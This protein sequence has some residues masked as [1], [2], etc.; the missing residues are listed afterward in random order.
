MLLRPLSLALCCL[1]IGCQTNPEGPKAPPLFTAL[2]AAHTGID[3][4]NTLHYNSA[5][6]IYTYRNFYNGG[7]V[8]I[9]D[10]NNDG[11]PDIYLTANME[12]NRLY[13]NQGDFRFEDVSEAAGIQGKGGWCTG[14]AMADVN[15]DG[16][17]DIYVCNSGDLEGDNKQNE[18]F[19]NNGDGT[20][21]EMAEAYGL[22]DR[23]Y[24]THA[25]FFDYDGD[26]DLDCYLLNN[27]YQ[28]ISSFN[29]EK[30]ERPIRD[31]VGGD[32]LFRNNGNGTFTDVSVQAGIYGSVIGF[33]LGVTVGDVNRDGWPDIYVSNDFFER[34]YLYINQ[35]NGTFTEVLTQAMPSISSA[36]MGADMADI[37]H[38]GYPDVFVTEMLP[39]DDDRIKTATTFENWDK[40]RLNVRNGYHHQF[41]RNMLQLNNRDG[42]FS[43]IGRLGGVH[44]S[45]WSW[46]ALLFDMDNDGQ[47][48]I[49]VANGIYQDLTNQ[50][51]IQFISNDE[52]KRA[53]ISREG[54]DYKKLIDY[55]PSNPVPNHAFHNQGNYHFANRAQEWGLA[56]PSFSNGSAYADLDGDGDL[57]LV[58]NNVNM[59]LFIYRN[60]ARQQ[61][62][63]HHYLQLELMGEGANTFAIG[64]S[65]TCIIGTELLYQEHMPMRGFQSSV[66]YR[67]HLGLGGHTR[68]DTLVVHWPNQRYTLLTDVR[69]DTLLRLHQADATHQQ[70][71]AQLLPSA[72]APLL[73][74]S[75]LAMRPPFVH[76]ENEFI[77]FDR[78][79]LIY[80]MRSTQGPALAVADINGDGLDDFYIGGAK[81]FPGAL[82][83]QEPDGR[84]RA[85]NAPLFEADALAEDVDALFFDATGNGLPDLYVVSGGTEFSSASTG[86]YDRLYL[87]QGMGRFVKSEQ[88]LPRGRG[89]S[90]SCARAA[91][92]NGDGHLDL[93]VGTRERPGQYGIPVSGYLLLN[94]GKGEFK[95]VSA[96]RAPQLEE[97]GMITD[98][99]WLDYDNDGQPDLL[100]CG[101]WM[102]LRLF[103]NRNGYFTEVSDAMGLANTEGWWTRMQVADFNAD[104]IP[105]V[106]LGNH[107]LNS[108][109]RGSPE[110][111]LTLYVGDFDQNGSAEPILCRYEGVRSL[112]YL[113]RHDLVSQIPSLKKKYLKY[114]SFAGQTIDSIFSPEQLEAALRYQAGTLESSLLLSQPGGGYQLQPLP[115]EAQFSVVYGLLP[116]DLNGNGHIDLLLGGNLYGVKPEMGRYDACYGL[117]LLNNGQGQFQPRRAIDSGFRLSGEVRAI[118]QLR[119]PKGQT[120]IL[121]ARNSDALLQFEWID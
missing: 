50:D 2:D 32:K 88:I 66:D 91:D 93:F 104:G 10:V 26:G 74:P 100:V 72:A 29:L 75:A 121:V 27:S 57:D 87:N 94:N 21:T 20:F 85:I 56:S 54:V 114:E 110:R 8:A 22:A 46:G 25:V 48:D 89:E 43:D 6:N 113:L 112:P 76:Q 108:R 97:L 31:E 40:Y 83:L 62:P 41:T 82:Y 47:R 49:F 4:A 103:Q 11:L 71:P 53:I 109:F 61:H 98:A 39:S 59:P 92:F 13:L 77:D 68:I 101:E 33:G 52:T 95:D 3:F 1:L 70:P 36:S 19:I 96:E 107:G 73:R 35:K 81:G 44:A 115:V 106:V 118:R 78:D 105:D 23:G 18:L 12:A 58:V 80:H 86:L 37:D 90:G 45:D 15:G 111:P 120:R 38:D 51:Y 42:S 99:A 65:V 5:F 16:W 119:V 63:E 117:A 79:R 24:S 14:V 116:T 69:A 7:G 55:I 102:G 9:G 64:A 34:D 30:N 67:V 84:F 17:L 28:A 60:E